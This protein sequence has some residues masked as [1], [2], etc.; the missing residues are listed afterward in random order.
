MDVR[1]QTTGVRSWKH[2][3]SP[4]NPKKYWKHLQPLIPIQ[5]V[6]ISINQIA[7]RQVFLLNILNLPII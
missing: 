6:Y 5:Q 4:K 1:D 2:T 3:K 7:D